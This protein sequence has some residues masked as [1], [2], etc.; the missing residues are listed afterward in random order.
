MRLEDHITRFSSS[1]L[2]T[3]YT[4]LSCLSPTHDDYTQDLNMSVHEQTTY[5]KCG[6]I[7]TSANEVAVNDAQ[8]L[9]R[10][11]QDITR[12]NLCPDCSSQKHADQLLQHEWRK[13]W[14]RIIE[15]RDEQEYKLRLH[16]VKKG[17]TKFAAG[18]VTNTKGETYRRLMLQSH[19]LRLYEYI[20]GLVDDG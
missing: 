17:D 12:F 16:A 9:I 19:E 15:E 2:S 7:I 4:S 8:N 13:Q 14:E 1:N 5:I 10:S 3:L 20:D 18:P 6:H 11:G